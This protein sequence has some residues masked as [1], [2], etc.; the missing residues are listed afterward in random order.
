MADDP[1]DLGDARSRLEN[2]R[3]RAVMERSKG[4][5]PEYA[6]APRWVPT[7]NWRMDIGDVILHVVGYGIIGAVVAMH[8]LGY[9]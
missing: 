3:F 9:Y 2:Q 7:G 8:L 6:Y 1:D 5:N 4:S